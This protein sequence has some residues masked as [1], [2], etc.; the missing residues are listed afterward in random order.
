MNRYQDQHVVVI[1]M[2]K[3]GVAVAKLLH[4]FGANVVVNDKKSREEAT[5]AEEL[6]ALG[7]PVIC[8]YHPDD[9]IH[10]GVSLVVKNPGIPYEAPPV[11]KAVELG[12]PVV[13]EVELAYQIAKAPIIGITGSNGKTTTTTLVGLI[14]KEAGTRAM[15]GGNIGT[16]LCGLAEVAEPDQWLVAE[17]SSFQLMGTREFRPHIGVLL[18]LYP[19]H[20]DYH[21]TM[22]EYLAAKCKLFA[23]QKADDAAVL[24]F[25]QSEVQEKCSQLPARTY[26]FSKTQA[27][28]RG[29]YVDE[30]M[31]VF[32]DGEGN[33]DEIIAVKDITVP[34]VDNALAAVI[35][36]RLAGADKQSIAQVLST[37]PGVEHRMEFVAQ[38][39]GVKY[40]N[41][42]KA[43]NPEA[44]S[45]ALQACKEP[46]VWIC[47]GLD[48]GIDFRELVPIIQGRVK[49]VVALGET[50]PILLERAREA[51]INEG[52]RVDTVEKAVLA[53]SQ[54]ADSGDVVLLSPACASWD[55]FPSFEVRGSMFK[56]GVHR[57]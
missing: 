41:D 1:G 16:V 21:H 28:P 51:G 22:D 44:A 31:I 26:Y 46:I 55:M 50:A 23:N 38:K 40:F 35:V 12:I 37:F 29:A 2:A 56:D 39:N 43:T 54:L 19:A 18:N 36:T 8:G 34:H 15:V 14:L 11:A 42:S 27:V 32:V 57:L 24:P 45:R 6:E 33:R 9:L 53:A 47:G 17:L 7:I 10:S 49:A 13:T 30:G 20:L 4:R 52:I 25:D 48:R 5:G 3:S